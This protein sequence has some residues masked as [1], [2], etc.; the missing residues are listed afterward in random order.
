MY[1]AMKYVALQF[2]MEDLS[3]PK[4]ASSMTGA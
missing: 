2:H 4:S 3:I 1:V